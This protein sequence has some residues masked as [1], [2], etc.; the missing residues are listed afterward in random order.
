MIKLGILA[1]PWISYRINRHTGRSSYIF[2][3]QIALHLRLREMKSER[4]GN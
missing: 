3:I 1:G 2:K 4:E